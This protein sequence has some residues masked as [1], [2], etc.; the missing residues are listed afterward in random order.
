M[1][2]SSTTCT[3][4]LTGL[5]GKF[6]GRSCHVESDLEG[7]SDHFASTAGLVVSNAHTL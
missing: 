4:M 3:E 1:F 2:R 7:N 6:M 5:V